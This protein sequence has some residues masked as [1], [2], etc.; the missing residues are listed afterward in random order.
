MTDFYISF[1]GGNA[2]LVTY[3]LDVAFNDP[4]LKSIKVNNYVFE[5]IN[6]QPHVLCI[7]TRD[8]K[9]VDE[10]I[11]SLQAKYFLSNIFII[12]DVDEI[13]LNDDDDIIIDDDA[14]EPVKTK[15]SSYN[16]S[17]TYVSI[18]KFNYVNEIAEGRE[19]ENNHFEGVSKKN[20]LKKIDEYYNITGYYGFLS[21]IKTNLKKSHQKKI[22]TD[23]ITHKLTSGWDASPKRIDIIKQKFDFLN[24]IERNEEVDGIFCTEMLKML[25][26]VKSYIVIKPSKANDIDAV[27][28]LNVIETMDLE[29]L[30][31]YYA[32]L[33]TRVDKEF[34]SA[35]ERD[36]G[37]KTLTFDQISKII[38]SKTVDAVFSKI[39]ANEN[40]I[41]DNITVSKNKEWLDL[42]K[43]G[44]VKKI[45][46]ELIMKRID[47]YCNLPISYSDDDIIYPFCL[48]IF[49][50]DCP[51]TFAVTKLKIHLM[52]SLKSLN[53]R[54][55]GDRITNLTEEVYLNML[56][57]EKE[58][59]HE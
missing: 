13:E 5:E 54:K 3:L 22:I 2:A 23:L 51:K 17:Y 7:I 38:N 12:V 45:S 37:S 58:L 18:E 27:E 47:H 29:G 10:T 33:K 50:D 42:I 59:L 35:I 52:Y 55:V 32:E 11:K 41:K 9:N 43:K 19:P 1:T 30:D 6:K 15:Y 25:N 39:M 14:F 56:S 4:Q 46:S 26:S 57:L 44:N 20:I 48:S 40:F 49:L 53:T 28:L 21:M 31:A 24:G 36:L 8:I 16:F 34:M